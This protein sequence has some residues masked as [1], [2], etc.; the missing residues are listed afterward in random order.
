MSIFDTVHPPS[1]PEAATQ[2]GPDMDE[3]S[4]SDFIWY[5]TNL[6]QLYGDQQA[7]LIFNSDIS[8]VGYDATIFWSGAYDCYW[9]NYAKQNNINYYGGVSTDLYCGTQTI[10]GE[11]GEIVSGVGSGLS[12]ASKL[13]KPVLIIGLIGLGLWSYNKYIKK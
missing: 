5:H 4:G 9:I 11:A 8:I 7:R 10:T 6:K 12:F 13:I 1:R 3:W 2:L